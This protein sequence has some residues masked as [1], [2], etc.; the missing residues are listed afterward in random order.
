MPRS[1][2]KEEEAA[3]PSAV[4]QPA[5]DRTGVQSLER[6]FALLEQVASRPEGLTLAELA[7]RV[8]LH[9][10]TAFHLMKTMVNLGYARQAPDTKRYHVGRMLFA[11]A[12]G[13]LNEIELVGIGTPILEELSRE[14]GESSHLALLSGNEV[15]IAA[16]SAGPGAFQLVD[17]SGG[18]RPAHAT[19]LGKAILANLA[20]E[21]FENFLKSA[22]LE[23]L[24]SK[25]IT[26][27]DELRREIERIRQAGVAYDDGEYNPEVRCVAASV[28]D[29]SGRAIGSVGVSGPVWRMTLQ[30]MPEVSAK[31]RSAAEKFST[32]LGAR[33]I[34]EK[35]AG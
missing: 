16:R 5:K 12:A 22:R 2:V 20:P 26:E 29:F 32:A 17:R 11:L 14:T 31:V 23:P 3:D 34:G 4:E 6:A 13:S 21:K 25:S 19:A 30:R 1:A 18:I 33:S 27:P 35:T 9:N 15:V 28:R 8:G 24:T 7:K 10:S